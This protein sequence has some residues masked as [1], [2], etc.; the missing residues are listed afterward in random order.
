MK[1]ATAIDPVWI[2]ASHG[3]L[4]PRA[5]HNLLQDLEHFQDKI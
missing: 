1:Y 3:Y 5:S 2:M 4:F